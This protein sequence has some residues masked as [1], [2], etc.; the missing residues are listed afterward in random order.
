MN[1][2]T[3]LDCGQQYP[4]PGE[5]AGHFGGDMAKHWHLFCATCDDRYQAERA[6]LES[7]PV[8][9]ERGGER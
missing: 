3:C 7:T 2:H 1:E 8:L 5:I 4:C 9:G 6:R